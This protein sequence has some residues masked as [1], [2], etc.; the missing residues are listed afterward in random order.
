MKRSTVIA[1][2]VFAV[3][4]IAWFATRE[5]QVS[6]G[7]HRFELAPVTADAIQEI[8]VT[9]PA[10]APATG[11]VTLV[12]RKAGTAWTVESSKRAGKPWPAD[13]NV[14]QQLAS[15]LVDLK[16]P[17]FITARPEKLAELELDDEKGIAIKAPQRE[18]VIG[19]TSKNGGGYV[20]RAGTNDVYVT[21][22]PLPWLAHRTLIDF[23]DK[24]VTT[25]PGADSVAKLT[26]TPP[27]A[28]PFSLTNTEGKWAATTPLPPGFR[29]DAEAVARMATTLTSLQAV[30]FSEGSN[31]E[32][33][34]L[35]TPWSFALEGK[36]GKVVTVKLGSKRADGRSALMKDGDPDATIALMPPWVGEQLS[37]GLE[38]LRDLRA[39]EVDAAHAQKVTIT[40][41]GKKTVAQKDGTTWK[42]VEPKTLPAGLDFDPL[43][44]TSL[45]N[46]LAGQRALRLAPAGAEAK[47]NLKSPTATVE[48][49]LEGNVTKRLVYGAPAEAATEVYVQGSD[50]LLY[51]AGAAEKTSLEQGVEL[52]KRPQQHGPPRGGPGP[53]PGGGMTSLDQ[54]PPEIRAQIEAQL[55][56][57]MGNQPPSGP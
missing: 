34:G 3:L 7:I 46:R 17:D 48:V 39:F 20:R 29:L 32:A 56:G 47:A 16:A 27:G 19:K 11:K 50:G 41:A 22:S 40:T 33:E 1:V 38:G 51:V 5:P 10:A 52:F 31:L 57:Q 21:L 54:L 37:A 45:I 53:G 9:A 49:V 44:V 28:E 12:L 2:A 55:R 43:Q 15:A 30:D 4:L 35:G 14:A 25:L 18:L 24:H 36:D 26:V 8:S 6:V 13:P 23:R 42:V